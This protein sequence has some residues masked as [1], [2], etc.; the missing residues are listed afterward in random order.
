MGVNKKIRS[1]VRKRIVTL[2][3]TAGSEKKLCKA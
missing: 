1:E 3:F 2:I